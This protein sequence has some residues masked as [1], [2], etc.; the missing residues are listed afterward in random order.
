[1]LR[2]FLLSLFAGVEVSLKDDQLY[3][4]SLCDQGPVNTGKQVSWF[5]DN[6]DDDDSD[7]TIWAKAKAYNTYVL[8]QAAYCSCSGAFGVTDRAGVQPIGRSP[9]PRSRSSTRNQTAIR[10]TGQPFDAPPL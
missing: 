5:N 6:N 8:P 10:S 4:D 1:M 3:C 2:S 9:S 7:T